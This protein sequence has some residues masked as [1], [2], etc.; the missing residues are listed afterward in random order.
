MKRYSRIIRASMHFTKGTTMKLWKDGVGALLAVSILAL[1]FGQ[2]SVPT[3]L[4]KGT[5]EPPIN[6]PD[7][8]LPDDDWL[9]P[10]DIDPEQFRRKRPPNRAKCAETTL[11]DC[12]KQI[13]TCKRNEL[14]CC[15]TPRTT[16]PQYE[17]VCR[18][19]SHSEFEH[20]SCANKTTE[21]C[22]SAR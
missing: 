19:T 11:G 2:F 18:S 6:K 8:S 21:L 22:H 17:C 5:T 15:C 1:S 4:A 10:K 20:D 16:I 14:Q 9:Q 7:P 3:T 13:R 12:P